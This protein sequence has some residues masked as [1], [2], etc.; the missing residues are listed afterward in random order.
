MCGVA[1]AVAD[2]VYNATCVRC[3]TILDKLLDR[4]PPVV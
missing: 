2:S 4:W 1:A 3:A